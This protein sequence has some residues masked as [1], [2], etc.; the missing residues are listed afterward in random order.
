MS[1]SGFSDP[2]T[3][4]NQRPKDKPKN[5]KNSPWDFTCP[6]YDERSGP[7]VNAGT[8]YGIGVNQPVGH[9]GNPVANVS[10]LPKNGAKS[11]KIPPLR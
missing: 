10:S 5:G 8:N 11:I 3:P 4:V 6:Q 9:K 7:C 2:L 1:Y